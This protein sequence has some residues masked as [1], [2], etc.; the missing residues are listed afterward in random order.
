MVQL[1]S[2]IRQFVRDWSA[3]GAKEREVG[4]HSCWTFCAFSLVFHL[5]AQCA[6]GILISLLSMSLCTLPSVHLSTLAL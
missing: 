5:C 4:V 3:E 2:T 1:K 6:L